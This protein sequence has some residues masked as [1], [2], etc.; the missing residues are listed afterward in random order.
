MLKERGFPLW[1]P[2]PNMNLSNPYRAQGVCIGDVGI[3]T[4]FGAFDFLFN[5]CLPRDDPINPEQL[6][7]G[8]VPI[9]PPLQKSDIRKFREFSSRSYLASASIAESQTGQQSTGLTFE[10]SASEGAILTMPE[11]AFHEELCNVSRFRDYIAAHAENWYKFINGTRGYEAHNGDIRIVVGCDKTTAWGMATFS[12]ASQQSNF[13]LRFHA[14]GEQSLQSTANPYSWEHSGMAEVRVGPEP[15]D[16]DELGESRSS[17]LRNQCLFTRT[18]SFTLAEKV[19]EKLFPTT[20]RANDPN[21]APTSSVLFSSQQYTTSSGVSPA[22]SVSQSS[23]F[24]GTQRSLE[25]TSMQSGG[26][27]ENWEDLGEN[28]ES[29]VDIQDTL[30]IGSTSEA[31]HPSKVIGDY[32]LRQAPSATIAIVH[33]RDWH[34]LKTLGAAFSDAATL[35]TEISFTNDICLNTSKDLPSI[36]KVVILYVFCRLGHRFS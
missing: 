15:G 6:P 12:N 27:S 18:L 3:I 17:Q 22:S 28:Q 34:H 36:V 11:G 5:I 8:F 1:I 23:S 21:N 2:Q 24:Q 33:D 20:V 30:A 32:L 29:S 7:D 10:S 14:L 4:A 13:R 31:F 9:H 26:S 35:T 25:G 19:W 16:N